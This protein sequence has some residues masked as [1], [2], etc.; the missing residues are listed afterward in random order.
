MAPSTR[1]AAI[2]HGASVTFDRSTRAPTAPRMVQLEAFEGPLA[3][4][5]ALIEQRQLDVLTVPLGDLAGA[6]LEALAALRG[7]RL[8]H[9]ERVRHA[10]ARS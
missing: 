2:A 9:L 6:Y 4:L 8:P 10:S 3:L 1:S 5:L 7:S